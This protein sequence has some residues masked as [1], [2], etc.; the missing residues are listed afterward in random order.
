MQAPVAFPPA[1]PPAHVGTSMTSLA[2]QGDSIAASGQWLDRSMPA[3]PVLSR[4]AATLAR[5]CFER[6]H[7][8]GMQR[9]ARLAIRQED[10]EVERE[11]TQQ[12]SPARPL[13][14][15]IYPVLLGTHKH[16]AVRSSLLSLLVSV[17][18]ESV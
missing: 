7:G 14:K 16:P 12:Q 8:D 4:Y 2:T 6:L 11:R 18:T 5:D 17:L 1:L 9:T 13:S 10:L 15:K 3:E